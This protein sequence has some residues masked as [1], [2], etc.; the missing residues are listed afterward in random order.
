MDG[1]RPGHDDTDTHDLFVG[2]TGMLEV[3][4]EWHTLLETEGNYDNCP[5]L[6]ESS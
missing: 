6:S 4:F 5:L 3:T 1:V 2:G